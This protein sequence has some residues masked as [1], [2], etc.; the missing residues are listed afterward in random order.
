MTT[1]VEEFLTSFGVPGKILEHKNDELVSHEFITDLEHALEGG[2]SMGKRK[3]DESKVK[4]DG[5]GQFSSKVGGKKPD[6][7]GFD[8]TPEQID[9]DWKK[10]I[11]TNKD[12]NNAL[13][14]A[15]VLNRVVAYA[16]SLEKKYP[17]LKGYT[18]ENP[19]SANPEQVKGVNELVRY[20]ASETNKVL[21]RTPAAISPSGT[22]R[23]TY[24][25]SNAGTARADLQVVWV[26]V[27]KHS[28]M[29]APS[30]MHALVDST[31]EGEMFGGWSAIL[32]Y[33]EKL[34]GESD[35]ED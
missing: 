12:V 1:R 11:K 4:R 19:G 7:D 17:S 9:A 3:F 28:A 27:A 10:N 15:G 2:A 22:Q 21:S 30:F 35:N 20:M 25:V 6:S 16:K 8:R 33:L 13:N 23:L 34:A 26:P 32:D 31:D 5:S 18:G 29:D 24:R 14:K